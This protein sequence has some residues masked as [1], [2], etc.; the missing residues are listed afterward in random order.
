MS[1]GTNGTSSPSKN[2]VDGQIIG[3]RPT[4]CVQL[5]AKKEKEKKEVL[6]A[7]AIISSLV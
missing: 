3:S 5:T 7:T 1:F 4:R 6:T 2:R